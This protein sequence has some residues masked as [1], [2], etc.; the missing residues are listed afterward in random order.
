M[1][2]L[3][4]GTATLLAVQAARP[5]VALVMLPFLLVCRQEVRCRHKCSGPRSWTCLRREIARWFEGLR[6]EWRTTEPST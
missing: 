6:L 5:Q 2:P 3:C 1:C 4:I